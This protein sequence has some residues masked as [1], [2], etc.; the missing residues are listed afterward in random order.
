MIA[1]SESEI[2]DNHSAEWSMKF[3]KVEKQIDKAFKTGD[4]EKFNSLCEKKTEMI[5]KS[6][7]EVDGIRKIE[8]AFNSGYNR[9]IDY[10]TFDFNWDLIL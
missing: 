8:R 6:H 2:I 4:E 3:F 9:F 5:K 7:I 1:K 10:V